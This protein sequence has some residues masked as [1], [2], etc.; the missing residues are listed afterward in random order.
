MQHRRVRAMAGA[1]R[2]PPLL[3]A[4]AL[5]SLSLG[6]TPW[7]GVADAAPGGRGPTPPPV[8]TPSGQQTAQQSP[9]HGVAPANAMEPMAP[10]LDRTGW[11]AT[12]SDEETV[13][14]NGRAA[15]VLDGNTATIWHSRWSGTPAP[16][17]H[18]ITVD[19]HRTTVVSA[20]VYQPRTDKANGRVGE[21]SISLSTDGQHWGSPVA[22]GTLA[23][24]AG[25]KTLGFAP[26]GARFVRLTALTEAG[27][28]GPWSSA[29]EL[30]LLG[31]PGTPAATV[32][33]PRTGWTATASDEETAKENGRAANV[34]DG[35]AGTIWHS[36]WSGTAAPLPHS[37][38]VDMHRTAAVS[39]LVYQPR[40]GNTH[41]RVGAYTVT[42]STDGTTFGAPVS[43]GTWRDDDTVKTATF[44]RAV[45]A[46]YIRL[47]ATSEAGNRGPWTSAAEIRLSGPA[48]PATHGTWSRITGFPLVPVATA[49]L[50]GDKLLAW[51]A[52]AVDRFGG[53]NG[54]TQTAILDL[55]TGKVTQRRIDNTGHDMFCPGIAMLADGRVLV[56]GGS[57]A[58]KASIYDPATDAWSATSNM[59]IARGYQAMTL[60]PSGEAFVLGG[61]WS[62]TPG[63]KSGEVWSPTTGTWRRLPGVP[64]TPAMT[65]DPTGAY[66][67][68]NHMWLYAT[69]GGK[70]LQLGPSKQMNWITTA[71]N[72]SITS[73]GTRADSPDAMTGNAVAYDVG[74]LLTLG[75]SP[76]YENQPAT[77]RAYTVDVGGD[78]RV[79]TARTGDMGHTRGFSNSVVLPDGKVAVFGGQALPVPFSDATSVLTPELWDP[80]TG[81]F[82][83]LASMAIPRNYHSVANLLPDGRVFSGGGGLCG[84]CATNHADG[85][86]FTP[87]YL[88]NADGSPKPRPVITGGVPPRAAAGASL[89][90][91]TEG[92]VASFV[93]MR[94]AAATHS[95]DNDQ[96]RVPLAST[97]SGTGSYTVTVPA[98]KG[99][100]LPGTYM[101]FALDSQGVPST[102]RFI[103]VT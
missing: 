67:A 49:V 29:A 101:L 93:L 32:D 77:R 91:T 34:L 53:S 79:H 23:D 22:T 10:V 8:A 35:E 86:V 72:G 92:P 11:T 81:R 48:A 33:L 60:L 45:T 18:S 25:A 70:V 14:E 62:G 76:A 73:A 20:L 6:L 3:I 43:S 12:A 37:I 56:T 16:L 4:F 31:D 71:G 39:A 50:P 99:V 54:Y 27:N 94:A 9:H 97:A 44:T 100:V 83:P 41:G 47:T 89:T 15:N 85:A 42:T 61:S 80:A 17:P 2:R 5:G 1:F 46:R 103:T 82:T 65:A 51:S 68:D 30:N 38:T 26:Q 102:A 90:V 58:E 66:R 36:R 57:N 28:R 19:M 88:L 74:K 64:A 63:D 7:L 96:R 98:D 84:D 52:Y 21:Y 78:G 55:K 40:T 87:P 69:S 24:D 95:T 13:K 75:G 59:N